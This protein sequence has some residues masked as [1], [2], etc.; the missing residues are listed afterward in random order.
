M[1]RGVWRKRFEKRLPEYGNDYGKPEM[2]EAFIAAIADYSAIMIQ[3]HT[4][5]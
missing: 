2:S 5:N 1:V 3:K 4:T